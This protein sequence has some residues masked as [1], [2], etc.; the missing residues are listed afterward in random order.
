ME[1]PAWNPHSKRFWFHLHDLAV[2]LMGLRDPGSVLREK[3]FRPLVTEMQGSFS[4][5]CDKWLRHGTTAMWFAHFLPADSGCVLLGMGIKKLAGAVGTFSSRDWERGDLSVSLY[6]ALRACWTHKQAELQSDQELRQ[7]FWNI[8][9]V[10][11][12]RMDAHALQLRSEIAGSL[13]GA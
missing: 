5:W 6:E 3:R 9:S 7:S 12:G 2:D 10:L 4:E 8:L 1:S 13:P 11:C